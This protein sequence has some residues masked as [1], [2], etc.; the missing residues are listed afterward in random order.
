MLYYCFNCAVPLVKQ[1]FAVEEL[2]Q[3]DKNSIKIKMNY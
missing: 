1:G 3:N 2:N